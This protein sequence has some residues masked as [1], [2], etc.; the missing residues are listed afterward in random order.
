M[1]DFKLEGINIYNPIEGKI[2]QIIDCFVKFYG[3]EY[4]SEI[5]HKLNNT[6]FF[7]LDDARANNT[8]FSQIKNYLIKSKIYPLTN[9]FWEKHRCFADKNIIGDIQTNPEVYLQGSLDYLRTGQFANLS[10]FLSLINNG[11]KFD[12]EYYK[13]YF[14]HTETKDSAEKL[15]QFFLYDWKKNFSIR[16]KQTVE[17]IE[18]I[19]SKYT[20]EED[21]IYTKISIDKNQSLEELMV[22]T[23]EQHGIHCLHKREITKPF[24]KF[25]KYYQ[26]DSLVLNSVS[27]NIFREMFEKLGI[28]LNGDFNNYINIPLIDEIFGD[29]ELQRQYREILDNEIICKIKACPS[30]QDAIKTL[31]QND[32]M[33]ESCVIGDLYDLAFNSYGDCGFVQ[34]VPTSDGYKFICVTKNALTLSNHVLFHELNHICE[35][36]VLNNSDEK[37][38]YK[39]GFSTLNYYKNV[40]KFDYKEVI[41]YLQNMDNSYENDQEKQAVI[42]F[43][44]VVNDYIT[45]SIDKIAKQMGLNFSLNENQAITS[46]YRVGFPLLKK[47]IEQNIDILKTFRMMPNPTAFRDLI[48]H[49]DYDRLAKST[50]RLLDL[51]TFSINKLYQQLFLQA[52]YIMPRDITNYIWDIVHEDGDWSPESEAIVEIYKTVESVTNNIKDKLKNNNIDE[53]EEMQ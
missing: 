17:E 23:L 19:L 11:D 40:S 39:T 46:C 48:G 30:L 34:L 35:M 31:R 15:I 24:Y 45:I 50:M 27:K 2:D 25:L 44:E 13:K 36:A 14:S 8:T 9:E 18:S 5:T 52:G 37:I 42:A 6:I 38:D 20:L 10:D 12:S 51:N 47:F 22:S 16:Y 41:N 3:E 32:V 43:N 53:K 33:D 4:R 28:D 7:F 21:G 1:L 26:D 49:D 29:Q